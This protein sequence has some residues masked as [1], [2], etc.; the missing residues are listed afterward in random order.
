VLKWSVF[1]AVIP[2]NVALLTYFYKSKYHA[3]Q[4]EIDS[5]VK[6]MRAAGC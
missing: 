1:L 6:H 2:L 5:W 3:P 4:E